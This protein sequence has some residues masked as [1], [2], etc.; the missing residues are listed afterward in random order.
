MVGPSWER[1]TTWSSRSARELSRGCGPCCDESTAEMLRERPS[2]VADLK[3]DPRRM[4]VTV[5]GGL[6][7]RAYP[8]RVPAPREL[9][10]T[11]AACSRAA[12]CWTR[13]T[14]S[15]SSYERAI[16]AHV[17]NLRKIEPTRIDPAT[18]SRSTGSAIGSPMT[19]DSPRHEHDHAH[20]PPWG[21][22]PW[23]GG[24]GWE[25]EAALVAG[26][27]GTGRQGPSMARQANSSGSSSSVSIFLA[28]RWRLSLFSVRSS[29][30]RT[31]R[32]VF[33]PVR[34]RRDRTRGLPRRERDDGSPHPSPT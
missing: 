24:L 15:R 19:D 3:I 30:A 11:P 20:G 31:S 4:L 8:D 23:R 27:R 28:A 2:V 5:V 17:K 25:R 32:S 7:G 12:S 10:R 33:S 21:G 14:A 9:A 16:D 13:S 22:P 29:E 34:A 1:T 6:A 26:R 18:C